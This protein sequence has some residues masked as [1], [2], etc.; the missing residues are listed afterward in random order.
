MPPGYATANLS[1]QFV[2][3]EDD[4]MAIRYG[5]LRAV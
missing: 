3:S 5:V 1:G 4:A 2:G